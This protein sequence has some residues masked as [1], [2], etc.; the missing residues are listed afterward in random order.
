MCTLLEGPFA[1]RKVVAIGSTVKKRVRAGNLAMA[2]SVAGGYDPCRKE[3]HGSTFALLA[4]AVRQ[5]MATYD[6]NKQTARSV[7]RQQAI[8]NISRRQHQQNEPSESTQARRKSRSRSQRNRLEP[9]PE[10]QAANEITRKVRASRSR[11]QCRRSK[12]T[13]HCR[14]SG[15][16]FSRKGQRQQKSPSPI[17][18]HR[19]TQQPRDLSSI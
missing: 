8:G 1:N 12:F 2:L 11:R 13:R 14:R 15:R 4:D 3:V 5:E 10:R 16:C 19:R 6:V 9:R 17:Q 18:R 7:A